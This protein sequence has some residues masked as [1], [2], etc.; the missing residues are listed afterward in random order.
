MN[1]YIAKDGDRLD[2]I[3]YKHYKRLDIFSTVL[4]LNTHLLER[5]ELNIGDIV[6]LPDIA[7]T[8]KIK[9]LK[10]LWD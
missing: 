2:L 6:Y 1:R 5:Y 8:P 4:E 10:A 7:N 9:E 3:V